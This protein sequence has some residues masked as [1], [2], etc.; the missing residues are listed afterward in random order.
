VFGQPPD[1]S[2]AAI[3]AAMTLALFAGAFVMFKR[4]D[5]YFA[6]VI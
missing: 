6:D 4:M 5:K 2:V 3:S 1:W